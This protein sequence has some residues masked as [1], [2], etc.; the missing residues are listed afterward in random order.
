MDAGLLRN[1][2]YVTLNIGDLVGVHMDAH[3]CGDGLRY[4]VIMHQP[5]GQGCMMVAPLRTWATVAALLMRTL[6]AEHPEFMSMVL[7][8]AEQNI[9]MAPP[10]PE[11]FRPRVFDLSTVVVD[12]D[13]PGPLMSLFDFEV[14]PIETPMQTPDDYV[15][16]WIGIGK[17]V[18]LH[19][20]KTARPEEEGVVVTTDCGRSSG[21]GWFPTDIPTFDTFCKICR[22]AAEK[23]QF[24]A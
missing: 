20:V 1:G 13:R 8:H 18:K 10:M 14:E 16:Q 7:D 11:P 15:G 24:G 6:S 2:L 5:D 17:S 9:H 3:D 22:M 21:E 19:R 12:D 4:Q 23:E